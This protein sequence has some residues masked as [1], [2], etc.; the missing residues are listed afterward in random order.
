M[1]R[2]KTFAG[3]ALVLLVLCA[4]ALQGAF[5]LRI[6]AMAFIDPQSTSFQRSEAW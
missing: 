5:A 6:G 1:T 2:W 3:R 4:L